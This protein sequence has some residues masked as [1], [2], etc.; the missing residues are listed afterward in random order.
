MVPVLAGIGW[1]IR[2]AR[3]MNLTQSADRAILL[4]KGLGLVVGIASLSVF[5]LF[6]AL[7]IA[8]VKFRGTDHD[9]RWYAGFLCVS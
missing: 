5:L 7:L 6:S 2:I 1:S 3:R 9:G 8:G 4:I